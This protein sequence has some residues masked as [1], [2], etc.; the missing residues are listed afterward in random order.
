VERPGAVVS[1]FREFAVLRA[2]SPR[3]R[4]AEPWAV[5]PF[6]CNRPCKFH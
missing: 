6:T 5:K 4:L 1:D 2:S 3:E